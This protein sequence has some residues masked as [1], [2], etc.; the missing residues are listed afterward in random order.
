MSIIN[1]LFKKK[2]I[3][4]LLKNKD[5]SV[6]KESGM[7]GRTMTEMLGVLAIIGVLSIGGIA[8]YN[9][10]M[11]KYRANVTINDINLRAVDLITQAGREIDLNLAEW[12]RT[13]TMGYTFSDPVKENDSIYLQISGLPERVCEMVAESLGEQF[14]LDVNGQ[15]YGD[16]TSL[17]GEDNTIRV[18]FEET[19]AGVTCNPAC[20]AGEICENGICVDE[21]SQFVSFDDITCSSNAECP[22]C[23]ACGSFSR[24][25]NQ[26]S[27]EGTSCGNGAGTC[28]SGVC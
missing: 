14:D 18:Y 11:D 13:S 7:N 22:E 19:G 27:L 9:Y 3:A 15:Q 26:W 5:F 24:C 28:K 21:E 12:G 16:N 2:V 10:A 17:C 6:T 25:D 1:K 8:G 20:G 4:D 23:W